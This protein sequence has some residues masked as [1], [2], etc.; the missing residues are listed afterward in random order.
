VL[1]EY[2]RYAVQNP[3]YIVPEATVN[4]MY[5]MRELRKT[6]EEIAMTRVALA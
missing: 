6:L 5:C 4:N 3:E 2:G 1:Y